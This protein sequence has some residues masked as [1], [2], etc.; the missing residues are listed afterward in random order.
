[1]IVE[2]SAQKKASAAAAPKRHRAVEAHTLNY[3]HAPNPSPPQMY[4]GRRHFEDEINTL[5]VGRQ[6]E[7]KSAF[8]GWKNGREEKRMAGRTEKL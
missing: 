8:E 5:E 1:M 3:P 7:E 6:K 2:V 4:L